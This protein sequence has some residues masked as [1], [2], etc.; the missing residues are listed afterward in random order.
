MVRMFM[1]KAHYYMVDKNK[2][3]D[4][5][6]VLA[7]SVANGLTQLGAFC[8]R[9]LV[10][11]WE[12]STPR[13]LTMDE[14]RAHALEFWTRVFGATEEAP[15]PNGAILACVVPSHSD[16]WTRALTAVSETRAL[17][18][19]PGLKTGIGMRLDSPGDVGSDRVA[20][21]VAARNDYGFP[22]VVVSLGTTTNIEVVDERGTFVGGAIAPGV[23]LGARA[24]SEAA[25]RLPLVELS[26]PRSVVGRNTRE[27]IQ[28]GVV[29]GEAARVDGLVDAVF[30]GLGSEAPLVVTG[31]H[32]SV[33]NPL[34]R[35]QTVLD[36]TLTL[37]GLAR[38]WRTNRR[39]AGKA[40]K[41]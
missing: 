5:T 20:N 1:R 32:A 33:V 4:E 25:A 39:D 12:V 37:R 27:A 16:A 17:V 34:L 22:V 14:A 7:V 18:V 23:M 41:R 2:T 35:H 19:G 28:A 21:V 30:E 13:H 9:R 11:T 40:G 8:G 26:V 36:P 38:I 3:D 24:L 29:L 31:H 15:R 6:R 10:G